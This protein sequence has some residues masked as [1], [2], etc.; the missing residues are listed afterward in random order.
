MWSNF[1]IC[2]CQYFVYFNLFF[3]IGRSHLLKKDTCLRREGEPLLFIVVVYC[4]CLL[5]FVVSKRNDKPYQRRWVVFDGEDLKYF[6][7]K[8]EKVSHTIQ[9]NTN[10]LSLSPSLSLSLC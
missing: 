7:A 5:L 4:C 10:L 3:I 8:G 6:K 1:I 9:Y 2:V